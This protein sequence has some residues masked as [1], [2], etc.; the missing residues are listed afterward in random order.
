MACRLD[1][2]I[3]TPMMIEGTA[4]NAKADA[5]DTLAIRSQKRRYR[6]AHGVW[7]WCEVG[8]SGLTGDEALRVL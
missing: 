3:S 7:V 5:N 8:G 2:K 6:L 1:A 4:C